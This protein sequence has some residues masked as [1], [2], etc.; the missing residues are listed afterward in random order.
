LCEYAAKEQLKIVA[1]LREAKTGKGP[2]KT[3]ETAFVL[4]SDGLVSLI[5]CQGTEN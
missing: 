4:A 2:M 5:L 1:S 3:I